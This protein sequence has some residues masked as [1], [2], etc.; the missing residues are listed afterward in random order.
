MYCVTNSYLLSTSLK[1]SSYQLAA[2]ARVLQSKGV[3]AVVH[4][5]WVGIHSYM[6]Y[7]NW[8][9]GSHHHLIGYQGLC[10]WPGDVNWLASGELSM[11]GLHACKVGT[12]RLNIDSISVTLDQKCTECIS[13]SS[14]S[15]YNPFQPV[16]IV[17]FNNVSDTVFIL[18]LSFLCCFH[19]VRIHVSLV[20]FS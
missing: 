14:L 1:L 9:V 7:C 15:S 17:C 6:S 13:S 20:R 18:H 19:D 4:G 11:T 2:G 3:T 12:N 10:V 8:L 5:C 16:K